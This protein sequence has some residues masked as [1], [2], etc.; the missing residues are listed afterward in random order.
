MTEYD[1]IGDV[2]GAADKLEGLLKTLGYLEV[3]GAYRLHGHQALFVGDL[4]DRGDDQVR[5]VELVRAMTEARS[6]QV[7]MGTT[8]STP[9]PGSHRTPM[10]PVISCEPT[11]DGVAIT[12][13]TTTPGSS[14]RS[15]R[16]QRCTEP[17][18]NGS[19]PF[20]SI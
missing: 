5:V 10:F 9:S 3:D 13:G 1:I 11:S 16:D 2:H 18:S 15:V 8:S 17:P 12:T 20:P 19:A 7:V 14:T 4:I 6:A